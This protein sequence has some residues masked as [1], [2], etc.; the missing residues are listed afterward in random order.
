MANPIG[1]LIRFGLAKRILGAGAKK[2]KG[3]VQAVA[4]LAKRKATSAHQIKQEERMM[5]NPELF[6]KA[7]IKQIA[8]MG[9]DALIREKYEVVDQVLFELMQ[10][11]AQ[12]KIK[13]ADFEKYLTRL[14]KIAESRSGKN[15]NNRLIANLK[16]IRANPVQETK[17]AIKT[18]QT[19]EQQ[20]QLQA[21]MA[22]QQQRRKAA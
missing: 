16:K 19:I 18:A 11:F 22:Q 20:K 6:E 15:R 12:N 3:A 17:A 14:I 5:K 21:A 8:T 4:D 10:R 13:Q 1:N 9:R 7:D 2:K